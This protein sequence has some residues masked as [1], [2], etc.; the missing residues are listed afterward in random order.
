MSIRTI[1]ALA[2]VFYLVNGLQAQSYSS[3][4][5]AEI[6]KQFPKECLPK[7][8]SIFDCPQILKSKS[9]IIQ[10]NKKNEIEHLGISLFSPETKQMI[11]LPVCNF[12][13][14]VSLEL[15]LQKTEPLTQKKLK[16][17]QIS[18]EKKGKLLGNT[19]ISSIENLLSNLKQPVRFDLHQ[20]D[21]TYYASWE[22]EDGEL[23]ILTFPA[24]RELIFG[25]NKKESD[26]TLSEQLSE[27][28][29]ENLS[30]N[31]LNVQKQELETIPNHKTVFL[32]RGNPFDIPELNS[33]T[34]YE[35][36]SNGIL[37]PVNSHVYP[38]FLLKNMLLIPQFKTT[39]KLHVKHRMYGNFTPEFDI[40]PS[41]FI[42]F[43]QPEFDIYCFVDDSKEEIIKATVVLYNRMF[44]YIH[45]LSVKTTVSTLFQKNGILE[46]EFFSNIPQH[47]IKNLFDN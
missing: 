20:H 31:K 35:Q 28:I 1:Y 18:L 33:D 5:M 30:L 26:L 12:I 17:Y 27:N 47:N 14:R 36:D 16:E 15:L 23:Y 39:L 4:K 21:G 13:E 38:A 41:N 40:K 34:Y 22:Q 2:L 42:C 32:K 29:C 9:F 11:N 7:V 6:G 19:K 37:L 25:T 24:S 43:F 8:N 46:A 45:L 3:I 10:Y 44:N